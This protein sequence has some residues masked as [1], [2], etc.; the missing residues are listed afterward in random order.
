[1]AIDFSKLR[2][3]INQD[4]IKRLEETYKQNQTSGTFTELPSGRYPVRVEKMEVRK[5][6]FSNNTVDQISID[7]SVTDGAHKGQH[8]FYNGSFDTHF[9]HGYAATAKLLS[10]LTDNQLDEN[11]IL[12][13]ITG[14]KQDAADFITELYQMIADA[15]EYDLDYQVKE[16]KSINPY[17]NKPY[18]NRYY[19]ITDVYDMV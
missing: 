5:S 3:K 14:S 10:Q 18:I 17:N 9:C 11:S 15:Y 4:E 13:S 1:M 2:K 19:T 7:F 16:S 8:I 12:V 6:T